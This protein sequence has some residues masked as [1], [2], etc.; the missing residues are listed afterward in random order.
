MERRGEKTENVN[1]SW[2]C[3]RISRQHNEEYAGRILKVR[4]GSF[5]F[6]KEKDRN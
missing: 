1:V 4:T 3:E 5:I 2:I 6:I